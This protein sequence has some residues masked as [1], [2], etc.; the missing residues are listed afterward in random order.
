MQGK[1]PVI[2]TYQDRDDLWEYALA[3]LPDENVQE[4]IG[5]EKN[6]L[7]EQLQLEHGLP[8]VPHIILAQFMAREAMEETLSRWIRNICRLEH[9]FQ[10]ELNNYSGLP[11]HTI[12]LRIQDPA[13]FSRFTNRLKILD[14]FIQ[15]ND[16]PPVRILNKPYITIASGLPEVLYNEAIRLFAQRNFYVSF[17]LQKL[18][19]VRKL[20]NGPGATVIESFSLSQSPQ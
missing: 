9:D 12:Y 10:V 8:P 14:S 11:P 16:C 1:L 19:L 20:W 17:R 2:N 5:R 6:V 15:S 7:R 13:P 18:V 4:E 3:A